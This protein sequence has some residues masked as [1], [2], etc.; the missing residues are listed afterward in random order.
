LKNSLKK[1]ITYP[2]Y[3]QP[4][5]SKKM[6]FFWGEMSNVL[7]QKIEELTLYVIEQNKIIEIQQQENNKQSKEIFELKEANESFK[8]ISERILKIESKLK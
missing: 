2:R 6:G 1:T 7:L 4:K 8:N 5:K 3:L